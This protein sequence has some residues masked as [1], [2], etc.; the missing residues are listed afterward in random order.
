VCENTPKDVTK[1]QLFKKIRATNHAKRLLRLSLN[2]VISPKRPT[3]VDTDLCD[4]NNKP[5]EEA[6]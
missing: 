2:I 1:Q 4:Q 6:K 3:E 5:R